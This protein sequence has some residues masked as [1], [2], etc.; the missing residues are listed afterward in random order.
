[1]YVDKGV[2]V[3]PGSKQSWFSM[4]M[5]V[6][7]SASASKVGP[8]SSSSSNMGPRSSSKGFLVSRR[9]RIVRT[10]HGAR[11]R[12][13]QK[14]LDEC[15]G[16]WTSSGSSSSSWRKCGPSSF[17]LGQLTGADGLAH[18][19]GDSWG[20]AHL[21]LEECSGPDQCGRGRA[22]TGPC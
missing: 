6:T 2:G 12:T 16:S 18:S 5:D 19:A 11:R 22:V 10:G 4:M 13:N 8:A 20:P 14:E 15:L 9:D 1:M 21:D 17:S 3:V 7:L